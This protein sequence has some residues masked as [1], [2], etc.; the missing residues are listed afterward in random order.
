MAEMQPKWNIH[1]KK[2]NQLWKQF[3]N[4]YK[5]SIY[6]PEQAVG[7]NGRRNSLML[8]IGIEHPDTI[9]KIQSITAEIGQ[10][11]GVYIMP[12]EYYHITVKWFGFLA[13]QKQHDYDIEPQTLEQ[14][15]EQADQILSKIPEFSIRLGRVN[16]LGGFIILEVEDNGAIAQI[17]GR[18][19]EE[20]TLVPSYSIEG[21]K[22]L[23]HM[24]IAGLTSLE[25]SDELKARVNE[26]RDI[27]IGEIG[28]SQIDLSQAILQK[29]CP[30]C[31]ILRPFPLVRTDS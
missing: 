19:H 2:F 21:E 18:F 10:I 9:K 1:S 25:G 3:Q 15:L 4:G 23:P 12:P 8:S 14:I 6:N 29:P 5:P 26:L 22:W 28:V 16:A 11:P 27:E 17:Q 30:H 31:R 7:C 13:D 20:A 24:S